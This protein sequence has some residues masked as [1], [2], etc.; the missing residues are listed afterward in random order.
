VNAAVLDLTGD[1]RDA[2]DAPQLVDRD[3]RSIPTRFSCLKQFSLSAAH[4]RHSMLREDDKQSLALRLGSGVHAIVLDQPIARYSGRRAGKAWEAFELEHAGKVILND[5]EYSEA[6]AM[7]S[8]IMRRREAMEILF[9]DTII[10]QRIDWTFLG[11]ACRS[12]PD[13]RG[14]HHVAELK[15][16]R[17]AH[18]SMF[19]RDA[20]RMH[21][22]CQL[23]FYQD[24]IESATGVMPSKAYIVAVEKTAP[25]PVTILE[26]T[27]RTL[28]QGRKIVRLWFEQLLAC[29]ASN[30]WPEY[31]ESIVPFDVPD[32]D[33]PVEIIIDG[34]AVEV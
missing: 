4:Y 5:R 20:I 21:Y 26:L 24:A 16:G 34:Q 15:T 11:R 22:H 1:L 8:A 9:V 23:A 31:S 25:Y 13:A 27:E 2:L 28:E 3:I 6:N 12:T 33:E 10:E 32:L 18:P 7:A 30:E 19:V 17:T 29:E 14:P